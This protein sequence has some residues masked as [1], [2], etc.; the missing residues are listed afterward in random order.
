LADRRLLELAEG[1]RNAAF[2]EERL[3]QVALG[4]EVVVDGG[5]GDAGGTGDVADA[6]AGEAA[7]GEEAEG[8]V[9]DLFARE[10]A[11]PRLARGLGA[12][13]RSLGGYQFGTS[14]PAQDEQ[15]FSGQP[16]PRR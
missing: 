1:G 7:L 5:V 14:S 4:G 3:E 13:P 10:G 8:G 16:S 12:W 11:A 9:Q 2:L 6:G 15:A